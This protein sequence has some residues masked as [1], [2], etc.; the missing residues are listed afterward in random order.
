M[1]ELLCD[2][3]RT[4]GIVTGIEHD[5]DCPM[6]N[7]GMESRIVCVCNLSHVAG[8]REPIRDTFCWDELGVID[9]SI[10][11]ECAIVHKR[12]WTDDPEAKQW[13]A[14]SAVTILFINRADSKCS[15]CKAGAD[16]RESAH[17]RRLGY[18][19]EPGARGCGREWTHLS[20][21]YVGGDS[22]L[23]AQRMQP[24]LTWLDPAIAHRV[25]V[26][27]NA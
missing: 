23:A 2:I 11:D 14:L 3:C 24:R 16:P 5:G 22:A 8:G 19:T 15:V 7:E 1:A 13:I 21:D 4:P 9:L 18:G 6:T 12:C 26:M 27:A 20:S 10:N 17:K 25:M